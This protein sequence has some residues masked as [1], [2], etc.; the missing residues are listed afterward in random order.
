MTK[1]YKSI[2]SQKSET[3]VDIDEAD[4]VVKTKIPGAKKEKK[5]KK[6]KSLV[7]KPKVVE[8]KEDLF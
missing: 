3:E 7:Q 1:N 4:K 5:V 8:E 6:A 2:L